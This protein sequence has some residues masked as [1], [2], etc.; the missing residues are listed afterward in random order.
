M[1]SPQPG[2]F[3]LGTSSHSYLEFDRGS[4]RDDAELV[5]AVASLRE[6]RTTMGG[7]MP[8][9]DRDCGPK[10]SLLR[11]CRLFRR[12][13]PYGTVTKHGTMFV[14]FSAAQ[15]RFAEMLASMPACPMGGGTC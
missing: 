15:G 7:S 6:P 4:G 3:A 2:I 5:A 14:G 11:S 12:N 10:S 13:M 8:A 9:S 1:R